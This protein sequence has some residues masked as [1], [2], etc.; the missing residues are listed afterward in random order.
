LS[1]RRV[2]LYGFTVAAHE[3]VSILN[4]GDVSI[5]NFKNNELKSRYKTFSDIQLIELFESG[6]LTTDALRILEEELLIRHISAED[7]E[8]I[9]Q[10]EIQDKIDNIKSSGIPSLP[11]IWVG[12]FLNVLLFI[13]EL[14]H[15]SLYDEHTGF[16]IYMSPFIALCGCYYLYVVN[17]LHGIISVI[18]LETYPISHS[19][20]VAF[21]FIP[22]Y[23]IYWLI[24][25]P[26][27]LS[28]YIDKNRER[29]MIPGYII[30]LL[31]ILSLVIMRVIDVAL[32]YILIF[33]ITSYMTVQIK[34]L[35]KN[36]KYEKYID[37]RNSLIDEKV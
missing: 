37:Y 10:K 26:S 34:G 21:H 2:R 36:C 25:W 12:F 35:V 31:L 17:R 33:S 22:I 13:G 29:K 20:A 28:N 30:G 18:S 27:E 3:Y 4:R 7:F 23:N 11:K 19:K 9:K 8:A 6:D 16:S 24:K 15:F 14:I 5:M 32:G 1:E